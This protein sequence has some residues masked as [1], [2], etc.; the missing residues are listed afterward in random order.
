MPLMRFRNTIW[1]RQF[2]F[3]GMNDRPED[4]DQHRPVS[5]DPDQARTAAW[6]MRIRQRA[7]VVYLF[8]GSQRGS[9]RFDPLPDTDPGNPIYHLRSS[10]RTTIRS[11]CVGL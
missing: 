4:Y 3:M 11:I 9:M 1:L 6:S 8:Y 10:N 5:I 2:R 7:I